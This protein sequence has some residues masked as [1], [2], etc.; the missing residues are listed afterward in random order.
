MGD[1]PD[2]SKAR[3]LEGGRACLAPSEELNEVKGFLEE[4]QVGA[5]EARDNLCGG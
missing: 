2:A 1:A 5:E 4:L 3:R